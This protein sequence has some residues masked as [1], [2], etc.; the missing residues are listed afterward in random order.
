MRAAPYQFILKPQEKLTLKKWRHMHRVLMSSETYYA[1]I[2][3]WNEMFKC[4]IYGQS[5][6]NMDDHDHDDDHDDESVVVNTNNTKVIDRKMVHDFLKD[7]QLF[8]FQRNEETLNLLLKIYVKY[9]YDT[10]EILDFFYK[11]IQTTQHYN[12]FNQQH[13]VD[14]SHFVVR[15]DPHTLHSLLLKMLREMETEKRSVSTPRAEKLEKV[16]ALQEQLFTFFDQTRLLINVPLIESYNEMIALRCELHQ[17]DGAMAYLNEVLNG[18]VLK[19]N[20]QSFEPIV[21]LLCGGSAQSNYSLDDSG[22]NLSKNHKHGKGKS[23]HKSDETATA[24]AVTPV[25]D[26]KPSF[27]RVATLIHYWR[28]ARNMLKSQSKNIHNEISIYLVRHGDVLLDYLQSDLCPDINVMFVLSALSYS[29]IDVPLLP[30]CEQIFEVAKQRSLHEENPE[31]ENALL[32]IAAVEG[33]T[34]KATKI[35]QQMLYPDITTFDLLIHGFN[36]AG[37]F[38]KAQRIQQIKLQYIKEENES[39]ANSNAN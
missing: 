28:K 15:F 10:S 1:N 17:L 4:L 7:F 31:P 12:Q 18:N 29:T 5:T 27:E 3:C 14:S 21:H 37:Q 13:S 8:N 25:D 39:Y 9:D 20:L 2:T 22:K 16:N 6:E 30:I 19:P 11:S 38:D 33:D 23:A 34:V 26:E 24:A 35:F 32:R 36:K